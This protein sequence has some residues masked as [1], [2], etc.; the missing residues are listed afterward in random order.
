LLTRG[1]SDRRQRLRRRG[2]LA[3]HPVGIGED[4]GDA[5]AEGLDFG[6]DPLAPADLLG[7][8]QVLGG[9]Q[10]QLFV[11]TRLQA[12]LHDR[13]RLQETAELVAPPHV[14]LIGEV[15]G[16]HAFGDPHRRGNRLA[17]G[18]RKRNREQQ[19]DQR[20][21]DGNPQH[22]GPR[23][24]NAGLR[25][26]PVVEAK[27]GDDFDEV[28]KRGNGLVAL[29]RQRESGWNLGLPAGHR[30]QDLQPVIRPGP[31]PALGLRQRRLRIR[32]LHPVPD[33][34]QVLENVAAYLFKPGHRVASRRIAPRSPRGGC[35]NR[36]SCRARIFQE[37]TDFPWETRCRP[38]VERLHRIDAGL[39]LL[40]EIDAAG[41][42]DQCGASAGVNKSEQAKR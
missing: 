29:L 27:G 3:R 4:G 11:R 20:G 5:G 15:S 18:V 13:E 10:H 42:A 41:F 40:A 36:A 34:L 1:V 33:N 30:L 35:R 17:H 16:G 25:L 39:R 24:S 26:G 19:S 6:F 28:I 2:Q 23:G 14:D 31:D 22:G 9:L 7:M 32:A 8:G 12:G 37:C 21:T 38:L